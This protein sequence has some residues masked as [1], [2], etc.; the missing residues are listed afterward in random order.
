M[1]EQASTRFTL[2]QAAAAAAREV[3]GVFGLH[4]GALGELATYGQGDRVRGVRIR[5][6]DRDAT[7]EIEVHLVA[8]LDHLLTSTSGTLFDLGARVGAAVTD[9]VT[10]AGGAPSS[11]KVRIA[12]L[13]QRR[14]SEG[15]A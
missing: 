8:D 2:A 15:D 3:P 12:D 4:D 10:E 5:S 13:E 7:Q 9:A 6:G 1:T 11:T 14:F